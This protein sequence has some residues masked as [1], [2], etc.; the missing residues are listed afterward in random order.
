MTKKVLR[1]NENL[2]GDQIFYEGDTVVFE[3]EATRYQS[4]N[5]DDGGYYLPGEQ[6]ALGRNAFS[7]LARFDFLGSP[8]DIFEYITIG[9]DGFARW[10]YTFIDDGIADG[11]EDMGISFNASPHGHIFFN[12]VVD[13]PQNSPPTDIKL[14]STRFDENIESGSVIVTLS[15][16]DPDSADSFSYS[17][18][19]GS[20]D[21]DNSKFTVDGNQLKINAKPDYETKSSYSVRL[22]TTD[23]G[24]ATFQKSSYLNV[25][26]I[27]E[28]NPPSD[29]PD[30]PDVV[31][32]DVV[33]PP[34]TS[35]GNDLKIIGAEVEEKL[36]TL[37][38]NSALDN[39]SIPSDKLFRVKEDG[40]K[41]KIQEVT[42]DGPNGE[43][44]LTLENS[45]TKNTE[46]S[47]TYRD[48]VSDQFDGILQGTTGQDLQSFDIIA[49]N[50]SEKS[51]F[52]LD[53]VEVDDKELT[54]EFNSTLSAH[55]PHYRVSNCKSTGNVKKYLAE[56]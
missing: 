22:Q 26:D 42:L 38:F 17:L 31:V 10:E 52:A 34:D 14:S 37:S 7:S 1:V 9:S 12:L 30:A 41:L 54:L 39:N 20:G 35:K 16:T 25:N 3:L 40:I 33:V 13:D 21:S 2:S 36:I 27:V 23:S 11:L 56:L 24:G 53:S 6:V 50:Q 48:L 45:V 44:T 18:I 43:V 55:D 8:Q 32:P 4:I 19:S 51:S 47:I 28:I 49:D 5:K 46:V 29:V 15:S